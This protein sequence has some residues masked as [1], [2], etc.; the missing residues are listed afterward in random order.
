MM[1]SHR[2]DDGGGRELHSPKPYNHLPACETMAD[3]YKIATIIINGLSS[4]TRTS[5]LEDFLRKQDLDIIIIFLQKVTQH[6]F[7]NIHGYAAYNNIDTNKRGKVIAVREHWT[8][9]TIMRITSRRGM[10]SEFQGICLVNIYAHSCAERRQDTEIFFNI[11]LPY[12]L[13]ASPTTLILGG[14][15]NCVLSKTDCKAI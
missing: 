11:D 1:R 6:V 3:T 2:K 14:D 4:H 8:L 15:F 7:D 5:I 10:A 9:T 13:R 12:L